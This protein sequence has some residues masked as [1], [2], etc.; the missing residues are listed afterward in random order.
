MIQTNTPE[1]ASLQNIIKFYVKALIDNV[2]PEAV[3]KKTITIDISDSRIAANTYRSFKRWGD[4]M[5]TPLARIFRKY[6]ELDGLKGDALDKYRLTDVNK[7]I[8]FFTNPYTIGLI[9]DYID[10]FHKEFALKVKFN[11]EMTPNF[12]EIV[13]ANKYFKKTG[14]TIT[15]CDPDLVG[16]N[17]L[18]KTLESPE[19][20]SNYW[21]CRTMNGNAPAMLVEC[22]SFNNDGTPNWSDKTE[23]NH[24]CSIY[25]AYTKTKYFDARPCSYEYWNENEDVRFSTAE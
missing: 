18:I 10:E 5:A 22:S 8:E 21:V 12:S 24:I 19:E 7:F 2:N 20:I 25:S 14:K 23:A 13:K 3:G 4:K 17:E 15:W 1:Y 9:T 11:K 16:L 6:V